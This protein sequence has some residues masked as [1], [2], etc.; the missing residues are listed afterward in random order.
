MHVGHDKTVYTLND[1]TATERNTIDMVYSI[2]T[3]ILKVMNKIDT[4][5]RN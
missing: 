2:T 3:N 5:L 1:Y 4:K